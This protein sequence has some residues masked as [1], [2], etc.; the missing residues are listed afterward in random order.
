[1]MATY[2]DVTEPPKS[3]RE[4]RRE[5]RGGGEHD[6]HVILYISCISCTT[7]GRAIVNQGREGERRGGER[8]RKGNENHGVSYIN[9]TAEDS[10]LESCTP[11]LQIRAKSTGNTTP[12]RNE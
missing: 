7:T 6:N 2:R 9:Y 4:R 3:D 5:Q 11:N 10:T 12:K 8:E 1:M